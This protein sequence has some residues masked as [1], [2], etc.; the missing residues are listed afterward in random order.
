MSD[1]FERLDEL[2][3]LI[4]QRFPHIAP[5]HPSGGSGILCLLRRGEGSLY[6]LW[7]A[8]KGEYAW[9]GAVSGLT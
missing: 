8:E 1:V 7:D 9:Y 6:V 5:I 4:E 2:S 3:A